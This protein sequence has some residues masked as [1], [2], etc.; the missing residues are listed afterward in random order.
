M[1]PHISRMFKQ[2]SGI[3]EIDPNFFYSLIDH[4]QKLETKILE[5]DSGL[6]LKNIDEEDQLFY[7]DTIH[8]IITTIETEH[9]YFGL[10]EDELSFFEELKRETETGNIENSLLKLVELSKRIKAKN[11]EIVHLNKKALKAD[12]YGILSVVLGVL[13]IIVTIMAAGIAIP[14]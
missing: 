10:N 14:H 7:L 9:P 12:L 2:T 3:S 1:I 4:L 13:S 8:D 6:E 5:K 11:L